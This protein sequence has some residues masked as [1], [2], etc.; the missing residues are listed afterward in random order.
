ME[1]FDGFLHKYDGKN[2]YCTLTSKAGEVF[3]CEYLSK[4]FKKHGIRENRRF[5]CRVS[6]YEMELEAIPDV[7]ISEEREAAIN[8]MIAEALG[9][10]NQPQNDY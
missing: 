10:D 6:D 1:E 2:A 7:E 4:E 5:K 3:E 8:K 9:D